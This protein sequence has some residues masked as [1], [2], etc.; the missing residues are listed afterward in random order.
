MSA[1]PQNEP[2]ATAG[3]PALEIVR[4]FDA[5]R[6]LVYAAWTDSVHATKWAPHGMA[7]IHVEAELRPG[8]GIR[9]GMRHENG[10]EHWESGTYR[11]IVA[12]QRLVFTHAWEDGQGHRGPETLVRI[13]FEDAGPGRTR[14]ILRQAGFT[15]IASRDGHR[16]GWS[17]AFDDLAAYFATLHSTHDHQGPRQ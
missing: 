12:N 5:P 6:S 8:G 13:E 10:D 11:E 1:K 14:M 4:V 3:E 2:Q 15:S 16:A 7:I 17:E 9:V